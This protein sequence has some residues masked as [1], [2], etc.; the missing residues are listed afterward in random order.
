MALLWIVVGRIVNQF[1]SIFIK[2]YNARHTGGGF[3]FTAVVSLASG[4]FF[5][6]VDLISDR[7]GLTFPLPVVWFAIGAGVSFATASVLTY[8]A[9]GCGSFVLSR[10][11]LSYGILITIGQGLILGE[12]ISALGWIGIALVA[13]S[14]F[15]VK[16]KKAGDTVPVTTKWVVT[17]GL[18]VLFAG[19]FGIL[20][21]YQQ[22]RFAH[23]Y[24]HE[25][26][27]L[28]LWIAAIILLVIGIVRDGGAALRVVRNGGLWALG[29]GISNGATNALT[30]FVYTLAPMSFVAP[31]SAG[32]GI[33]I[34]FLISKIIFKEKFTVLQYLGVLMG[35]VALVLFQL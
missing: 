35:G 25:F 9:L 12:T 15:F 32:A 7:N 21:R 6:A 20:Q 13:V 8:I 26:M 22:V 3:I 14:L 29:A 11:V 33:L 4:L 30:L 5:L 28:T 16:G 2:K 27:M 34:S 31:T 18:S 24:D 10:L 17:I 1:E 19:I 23:A